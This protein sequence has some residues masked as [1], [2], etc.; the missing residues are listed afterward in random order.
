M[1]KS[2]KSL[3][4]VAKV[5]KK[6][7]QAVY[8]VFRSR[9]YSL[10]SKIYQPFIILDGRKF[11]PRKE[12]GYWRATSGDRKQLHVYV[13]EKANG[14]LPPAHGIHHKDLDRSNNELE[15]LECLSIQEISSKHNPHFNQHTTPRK[16]LLRESK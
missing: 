2:G 14:K 8:D 10:R 1:Y 6:T 3:D 9:G 7:R 4:E 16:G 5:Y 15:N 13:W 11:A 12:D